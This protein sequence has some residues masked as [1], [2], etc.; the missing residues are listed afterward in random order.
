MRG[1]GE[2]LLVSTYEL[3]HQPHGLSLPLAFLQRAGFRPRTLD[4][5]VE[6]FDPS[7]ALAAR[8]IAIS[9]PMHTALRLGI[10][11]ARRLRE[12]VKGAKLAFYG[13]YAP[14][15]A[16]LLL[17]EGA[18]AVLGG[19]C[20]EELVALSEALDLGQEELS[21]FVERG[22]SA[23]PTRR[24]DY[25][26]PSRRALPELSRYARLDT[27]EAPPRVTGYTESSRG[28]KH[29]CRHCPIPPV[30]RGKFVAIPVET[31]LEDVAAQVEL[32]ARHLTFGDPDF[33]NGPAHALRVA[34]AV[35]ARFPDLTFDFT[36]KVE[37][38]VRSA[39]ALPELK[40]CG[41]L[42]ATSAVESFSDLVLAKLA[43]GHTRADAFRA[44]ELCQ[45]A[46]IALRPSL[47][48]FTPWGTLDNLAELFDLLEVRGL[49][50][51]VDPVQ[52]TVRLLVPARLPPRGPRGHRLHLPRPRR[53]DLA[54]APSRPADG[55][56]PARALPRRGGRRK[57][58]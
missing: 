15:N 35:K 4:L 9:V 46:G 38:L 50:Q 5:A 1:P 29:L 48:P 32:G 22:G 41:A 12:V 8:L 17:A 47:L 57:D 43:K 16:D 25:P 42:F 34:E 14:L 28:C 20:E 45:A 26:V 7:R 11:A 40:R 36:A 53:L 39:K 33:L 2:I 31:V 52:L 24:L 27:P 56:P 13:L 23:A 49:L 44:F 54:L 21:R 55:R 3:G 18:L 10:E 30:Y 58:P 6:P 19:E 37:H 51:H